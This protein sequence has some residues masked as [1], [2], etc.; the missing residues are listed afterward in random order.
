MSA[1]NWI[2]LSGSL[3]AWGVIIRALF[4]GVRDWR[5]GS[6]AMRLLAKQ[7]EVQ[8]QQLTMAIETM[9]DQTRALRESEERV[10]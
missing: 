7:L 4:F 6:P 8:G 1:E 3:L 2:Q 10:L 9:S 5:G